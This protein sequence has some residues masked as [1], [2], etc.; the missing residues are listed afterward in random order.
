[1]GLYGESNKEERPNMSKAKKGQM[2][3]IIEL[4]GSLDKGYIPN[5][6]DEH[7]LV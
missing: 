3:R 4:K 7:F 5:W 1:M 2:V 6:R